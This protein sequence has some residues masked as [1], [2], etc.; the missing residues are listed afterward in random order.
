MSGTAVD[1]CWGLLL[2]LAAACQAAAVVTGRVA[3][4]GATLGRLVRSR[5]GT[6]ALALAWAWFGWHTFAR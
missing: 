4:L 3:T 1:A 5:L 6:A 2:A